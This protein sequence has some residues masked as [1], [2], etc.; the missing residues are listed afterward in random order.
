MTPRTSHLT[1][2]ELPGPT[3]GWRRSWV[4]AWFTGCCAALSCS[5]DDADQSFEDIAH[6]LDAIDPQGTRTG[7]CLFLVQGD[8]SGVTFKVEQVTLDNSDQVQATGCMLTIVQ[9]DDNPYWM[10]GDKLDVEL[11]TSDFDGDPIRHSIGTV[12]D[13]VHA[14]KHVLRVFEKDHADSVRP[15]FDGELEVRDVSV[16]GGKVVVTKNGQGLIKDMASQ[17]SARSSSAT[18]DNLIV[19]G[20]AEAAPGSQDGNPVNTPGWT[21]TGQATALAY[22][23]GAYPATGDPGPEDRGLNFLCGGPSD[24]RSTFSQTLDLSSYAQVVDSGAVTFTLS[25][26][27]GGYSSQDDSAALAITFKDGSG[28]P[29]GGPASIGPV[30]AAE[31]GN[32]TALLARDTT[33]AVP[34]QTRSVDVELVMTRTSGS[35]NDGYADNLQLVLSGI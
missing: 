20:D 3:R 5:S 10:S 25:A 14:G 24:A 7:S 26:Y 4:A 28:T 8:S 6:R 11:R 35:A 18:T 33:G 12:E 30:L 21:V 23:T 22:G 17:P 9:V 32:Q 29:V 1:L 19:N 31:R 27:L 34:P 2:E 16:T 15:I 13:K